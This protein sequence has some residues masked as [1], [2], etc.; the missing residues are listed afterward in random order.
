MT[1]VYP[2]L[3]QELWHKSQS[4]SEI[5]VLRQIY[6]PSVQKRDT[7]RAQERIVSNMSVQ[8]EQYEREME[9]IRNRGD[10]WLRPIGVLKTVGQ[11]EDEEREIHES[12]EEYEDEDGELNQ[13]AITTDGL[14]FDGQELTDDQPPNEGDDENQEEASD[15]DQD[16]EEGASFDVGETT[17]I[18]STPAAPAQP[19]NGLFVV[20]NDRRFF[21]RLDGSL[22]PVDDSDA[23]DVELAQQ[24]QE[25]SVL[26]HSLGSA[27][28]GSIG[29]YSDDEE[30]EG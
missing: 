15:L 1:S 29:D 14:V 12:Y 9:R 3:V 30:I 8:E 13:N 19:R 7:R 17:L 10:H 27:D 11:V 28:S 2:L 18:S 26:E 4:D 6:R 22:I 25:Y 5:D 24:E 16:V 23:M 20:I 21:Q